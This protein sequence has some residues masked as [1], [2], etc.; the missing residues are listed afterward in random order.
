MDALE[1][2][3]ESAPALL[4]F[5]AAAAPD[6]HT[7]YNSSSSRSAVPSAFAGREKKTLGTKDVVCRYWYKGRCMKEERCEFLHQVC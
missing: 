6:A 3:F 4:A 7:A 2:D 5:T 1:F